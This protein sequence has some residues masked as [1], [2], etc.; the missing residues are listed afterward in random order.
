V[1]GAIFS[2]FAM[3]MTLA[4]PIRAVYRLHDFITLRHLEN[5]AKVILY[6]V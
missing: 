6:E 2:G 1:A 4:I 3:V 5:M